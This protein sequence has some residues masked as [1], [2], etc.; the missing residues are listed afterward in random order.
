MSNDLGTGAAKAVGLAPGA[1]PT[2]LALRAVGL[3]VAA[4]PVSGVI[5]A[6]H[7]TSFYS[8]TDRTIY[9]L[10]GATALFQVDL[11]RAVSAALIDQQVGY[12][13]KLATLTDAQRIGVHAIVDGIANDVVAAKYAEFPG[14]ETSMVQVLNGRLAGLPETPLFLYAFLSSY[15][16]GASNQATGTPA[17]ALASFAVP[18]SDAPV[19]DPARVDTAA[20]GAPSAGARALGMEFWFGALVPTLGVD[21]A[22]A[23]MLVWN[24]ETTTVST[25]DGE[26]CINTTIDALD[27]GT[28][29]ELLGVMSQ[30]VATRPPLS[31]AAA[32]AAGTTGVTL[33]MCSTP[34]QTSAPVATSADMDTFFARASSER[35][36]LAR[37]RAL[38]LPATAAAQSCAVAFFRAGAIANF[39][40]DSNDPTMVAQMTDLVTGCPGA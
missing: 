24:G 36:L 4:P 15:E 31:L 1:V 19:F 18:S 33:S 32:G 40:P 21:A 38:G 12:T 14:L 7:T 20:A 5:L 27:A 28:Q 29:A 34:D 3:S 11:L 8:D 2:S 23:A 39:D 25:L 30:F 9:R 35:S 22:R 26:G 16:H 6:A 17:D 37:M 13:D 10:D